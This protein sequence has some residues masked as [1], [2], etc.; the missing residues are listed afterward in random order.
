M[1]GAAHAG[2][3]GALAGVAEATI[4]EMEALGARAARIR[5]VIGPAIQQVSYEVGAEFFARFAAA[6]PSSAGYFTTSS[7]S[8]RYH[9]DLPGFVENRLAALGL[10]AI[11]RIGLDTCADPGRFFSYRRATL[12]GE[13]DYGRQISLIALDPGAS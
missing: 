7:R 10:A 2:W 9:F 8:G 3:Q 11:G 13:P 6:D 4:A 5:A 1:I 12:Q